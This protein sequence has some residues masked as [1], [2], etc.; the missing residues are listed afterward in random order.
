VGRPDPGMGFLAV[1]ASALSAVQMDL[2]PWVQYENA[3]IAAAV[4][5]EQ[6]TGL[7]VG[8]IEA[9][10]GREG[11]RREQRRIRRRGQLTVTYGS[12]S[13]A[14]LLIGRCEALDPFNGTRGGP[15]DGGFTTGRTGHSTAV[16]RAKVEPM[17][18][19]ASVIRAGDGESDLAAVVFL[20][21]MS[22]ENHVHLS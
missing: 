12:E 20:C 4:L 2:S 17:F 9:L 16:F 10:P 14:F 7:L 1:M 18:V 19:S 15:I 13:L 6:F 5:F 8:S 21:S 11:F 22:W 3:T